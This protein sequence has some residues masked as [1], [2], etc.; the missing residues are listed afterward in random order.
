MSHSS[1]VLCSIVFICLFLSNACVTHRKKGHT[2]ALGRFY[3][4]TTAKYNGYFNA[5]EIMDECLLEI[6]QSYKDNYSKTL[7]VFAYNSIESVDP[8]KSK[9][10]KAIEKVSNVVFSHRVSHW[11]D[12]CYLIL[13]KAQY[14]K[15]DYETAESSFRFF[16]EEFDPIKNKIKAKK[17]KENTV[18]EKKKNAEDLKKERKK[19]AEQ[20][21]KEKKQLQ[22]ER[23]KAKKNNSKNTKPNS[24]ASKPASASEA[25]QKP[26]S[27]SESELDKTNKKITNEGSWLFPHY[28]A[29][30]EGAIWAAKNL[31]ARGKP[32]EAEQ[33]LKRVESDPLAPKKLKGELYATFADLYLKTGKQDKAILA[34]KNAVDNT[35]KKRIKARYA[36]ILGQLYQKEN[37]LESSNTYFKQ[38][39]DWKP[40]YDLTFHC[41]MNL[42]L[43]D[44]AEGTDP[45]KIVAGIESL[46]KDPKNKDF[47]GELYYA[48]GL[49]SLKNNK[50]PEA[51][52]QFNLAL[53]A[54]NTANSQ[55]ADVYSKL[56]D[57]YFDDQDYL[58]AKL[59]YDSTL[60]MLGKNDERRIKVSKLVANLEEIAQ[61]LQQIALQDSLLKISGLSVKDKRALAIQ[62]KNARKA[63]NA[64][65]NAANP[66][67]DL[68]NRFAEMESL[69]NGP[70]NREVEKKPDAKKQTSNFFAYDQRS[71]NRGRSEFEQIWG[72]RTLED[73]WRRKNKNTF[74]I[75]EIKVERTEEASDTLES[76][77]AQ[78]LSAIPDSPEE[79]TIAKNKIAESLYALGILYREKLE[80]YPKSTASLKKLLEVYPKHERRIDALYYLYLNC[81]DLRDQAC[82]NSYSDQIIYEFPGS[83]YAKI[84]SDPEYVKSLLAKRD[85]ISNDYINA[86]KLY[87]DKNFAEAYNALQILKNKIK[88]PH[89]LEAKLALLSALCLGNTQGKDV[90]INA[91]RDVVANYPSTAEEVK[92]KEILRFLKG[93]QDAFV[94]I[95]QNTLDQTN[96]KLEDDKMHFVLIVFFDPQDKVVDKAKISISDYNQNYHKPENL[97]MTSVEL[98]IELNQPLIL[99]RKFDTRSAAMKYYEGIQRKPKEF[100]TGFDN[101]ESFVITQNNYREVLRLKTLTEYKTFFKKN[102]L[103][104]K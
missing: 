91:L 30:W 50:K 98:D 103:E 42:L 27:K 53:Q 69:S 10:D 8:Q 55:K 73:N 100:I 6:D 62:L 24:T 19:A 61:H 2:S 5:N 58:K 92:A 74:S 88:P 82:A 15:K 97:K 29:F 94:E 52:E 90:Y 68:R 81:L 71:I 67:R 23:A 72:N 48:L 78:I 32:F 101:W 9:L 54:A 20:K 65:P 49:I 35:K 13:C 21:A 45:E 84:L 33:L 4:N 31:V 80:N 75:N 86:Y 89:V 40:G 70:F 102:Y 104:G 93:D 87:A 38:C 1:R 34:L 16:I 60:T 51:L 37:R 56:A 57:I 79:I 11:A 99:I 28:P 12:D 64:E 26:V 76:D 63:K 85:E 96:F 14:L 83:H 17:I 44:A 18:K 36:F 7:P 43:N 95:S 47:Q 3:H 77:L 22:K 41:R 46:L 66:N 39:M 59:Y 25:P